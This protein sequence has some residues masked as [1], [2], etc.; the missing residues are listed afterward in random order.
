MHDMPTIEGRGHPRGHMGE[1]MRLH[2]AEFLHYDLR[3]FASCSFTRPPTSS[4][5]GDATGHC[6]AVDACKHFELSLTLG[7]GS[8]SAHQNEACSP[9][10]KM[11]EKIS[12]ITWFKT[13]NKGTT[14]I[15][16]YRLRGFRSCSFGLCRVI[17]TGCSR[18]GQRCPPNPQNRRSCPGFRSA[19]HRRKNA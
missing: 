1:A 12:A 7:R 18:R 14:W 10:N 17:W 15:V 11:K 5:S 6:T 9:S 19:G 2:D 4:D 16:A 8:Q 3:D 13:G